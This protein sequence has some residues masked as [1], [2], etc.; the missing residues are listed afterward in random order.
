LLLLLLLK[1]HLRLRMQLAEVMRTLTAGDV[2]AAA[3]HGSDSSAS[4]AVV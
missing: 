4:P 1:L 3:S 2:H